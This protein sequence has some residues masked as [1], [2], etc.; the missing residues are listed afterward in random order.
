VIDANRDIWLAFTGSLAQLALFAQSSRLLALACVVCRSRRAQFLQSLRNPRYV[1]YRVM[2]CDM[3]GC[4]SGTTTFVFP[5]SRYNG[6]L[7]TSLFKFMTSASAHCC[8][9]MTGQWTF[10][11]IVRCGNARYC[12]ARYFSPRVA[13]DGTQVKVRSSKEKIVIFQNN[14]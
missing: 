5:F 10:H 8:I 6:M 7:H 9:L 13:N 14:I 1:S 12:V 2:S 3:I 4:A 11:P